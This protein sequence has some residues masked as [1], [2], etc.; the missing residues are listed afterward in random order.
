MRTVVLLLLLVTA[1]AAAARDP[2]RVVTSFYPVYVAT[3]NVTGDL[4]GVEVSLMAPPHVGCLHDY[5][6]TP[7]DLRRLS[8]ADLLLANGAGMENFL[9]RLAAEQPGLRVVRVS[10]GIELIDGNPHVWVGT[11]GARRQL[12]N[13]ARALSEADPGRAAEFQ[14]NA[15]RYDERLERLGRDMK[16]AMAAYEGTPIVTFHEAFPYL[17]RE[18][19]LRVAGTI[20]REPG[21]EPAAGELAETVR[22]VRRTGVKALFVEPQFSDR[23]AQVIARETGA[24]VYVLD[25]VVTGPAE[26]AQ[27]REAYV[28]AMEGNLAVLRAALDGGT[29]GGAARP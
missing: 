11:V 7:A 27:A 26:P 29:G 20:Q 16:A 15:R 21:T 5:Q 19:G 6:I 4:P 24:A 18:L 28:A 13:I 9:E 1:Q 23:A 22:T 14:A 8:E 2:L 3:L 17:A 12:E 10:D 25:P